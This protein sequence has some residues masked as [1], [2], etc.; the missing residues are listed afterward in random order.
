MR[1]YTPRQVIG[2]IFKCE[3]CAVNLAEETVTDE[4]VKS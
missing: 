4:V 2:V 3:V 1:Q